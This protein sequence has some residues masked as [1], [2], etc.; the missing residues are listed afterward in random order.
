MPTVTQ[1]QALALLT[2]EVERYE[3]DELLEVY[4]ELFRTRPRT[5][6]EA[7]K[8]PSRLVAEI[9]AHIHSGLGIDELVHLWGLI[10]PRDRNVWYNEEE[11]TIYY[12]EET[13]AATLE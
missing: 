6:E 12:N 1:D 11:D 9:V 13:E 8:D 4:N 7:K 5:L 10:I 2:K 3:T